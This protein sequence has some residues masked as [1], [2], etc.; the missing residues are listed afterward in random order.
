MLVG[1]S[2]L[3]FALTLSAATA[4]ITRVIATKLNAPWQV[5]FAPHGRIFISERAGTIIVCEPQAAG[6]S[7]IK[8]SWAR[9]TDVATGGE[10]GLLGLALDPDFANTAY[11][12]LAY[13]YQ[14]NGQFYNRLVRYREITTASGE[15]RGIHDKILLDHIPGAYYHDGGRLK[16]HP[17]DGTLFWSIGDRGVP[18]SAQTLTTLTGKVLRLTRTAAIPS[19]NPFPRSY[20]FSYGH[21][22]VQGIAFDVQH[23]RIFA[24]EHGPS[25]SPLCCR[26]E[27]N[28][29]FSGSNYGWPLVSGDARAHQTVPPLVHSGTQTTWA[30]SGIAYVAEGAWAPSLLVA[31]LRGQ[32]LYR[33]QLQRAADGRTRVTAVNK[34]FVRHWGRLR[35]VAQAPKR[36]GYAGHYYL[37]TSNR[38]GRGTPKPDDDKLIQ[39]QLP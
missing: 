7:Y 33:V 15:R 11:V 17:T 35:D 21:R 29:L 22:N 3:C 4:P 23:N 8:R 38:D 39:L 16:F 12:Y 2:S 14:Q 10:A 30:P 26:D 19:N 31:G 28:Q 37:L 27:I 25:G 1:L 13:T 20:I 36:Y 6:S 34:H 24:S 32:T 9:L 18:Q 5:D